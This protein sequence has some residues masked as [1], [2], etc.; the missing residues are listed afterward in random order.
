MSVALDHFYRVRKW[1]PERFGQS[2]RVLIRARGPGPRNVLI[3]FSD[4][5]KVIVPRYSVRKL[6]GSKS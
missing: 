5:T 4:G 3:Q 2:C 6:K 1:M